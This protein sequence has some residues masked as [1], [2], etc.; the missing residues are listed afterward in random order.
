MKKQILFLLMTVAAL[1]AS[2]QDFEKNLA[3][4]KSSYTGGNLSDARFAM[5]QMLANL[6][7]AIGKEILTMLPTAFGSLNYNQKDDNVT[8]GGGA[9][10]GLFVHRTYGAY[11]KGANVD[12]INNSPM[13]ASINAMLN[14][15]MLGGMMKNENQKTVKVQGYKAILQKNATNDQG[16]TGYELQ[17][18]FNNTLLTFKL[19]DTDENEVLQFANNI[20]MAKI[21]QV[22]Q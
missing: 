11:P 22:A 21:A 13:I 17:V 7:Q 16:K 20:P 6:D 10:T 18:P 19:D 5:E 8:G 12:I 1:S 4:A 15:P 9:A 2:A 14:T 3:S